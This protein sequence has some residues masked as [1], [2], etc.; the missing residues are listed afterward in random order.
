MGWFI[1][2]EKHSYFSSKTGFW[3]RYIQSSSCGHPHKPHGV[4]L[5][6]PSVRS[7]PQA[8]QLSSSTVHCN[9]DNKIPHNPGTKLKVDFF[10]TTGT[11]QR[12]ADNSA[13]RA[14]R[15]RKYLDEVFQKPAF[16]LCVLP[17]IF[18]GI[19]LRTTAAPPCLPQTINL[20]IPG[21]IIDD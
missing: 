13:E 19:R 18:G 15:P 7:Q 4:P 8:P 21:R 3:A 2:Y 11:V 5:L 12:N 10:S 16:S 6:F 17:L 20:Y 14:M 9:H 1:G